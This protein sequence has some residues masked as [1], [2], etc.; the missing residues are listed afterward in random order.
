MFNSNG[1]K[2]AIGSLIIGV[3]FLLLFIITS[4]DFFAIAGYLYLFIAAVI[5]IITLIYLAFDSFFNRENLFINLRTALV[6]LLN[7]PLAL[8]C[9]Y[10]GLSLV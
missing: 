7:I 5:N 10:I 4:N 8:L 1:I 3:L 2:I 9:A 6:I